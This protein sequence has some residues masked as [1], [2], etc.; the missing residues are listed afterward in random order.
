MPKKMP[1]DIQGLAVVLCGPNTYMGK[2]SEVGQPPFAAGREIILRDVLEVRPTLRT[3]PNGLPVEALAL[4]NLHWTMLE[5]L[6]QL[7]VTPSGGYYVSWLSPESQEINCEVYS[8]TL[9]EMRQ[10]RQE[11]LAQAAGISIARPGV[12][13]DIDNVA[14]KH[15]LNPAEFASKIRGGGHE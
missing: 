7:I 6:P 9:E 8:S 2:A 1:K 3:G 15:N 10:K 4:A 14:T 11:M 5:P 12:L 13:H